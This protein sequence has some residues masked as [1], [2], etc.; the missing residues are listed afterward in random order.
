MKE[1]RAF[2]TK[3]YPEG[4]TDDVFNAY[5]YTVAQSLVHVLKQAGS[6]LSR[7]NVMKQAASIKDLALPL[8]LPGIKINTSPTDF[9]PLEQE[10]LARFDGERWVLFG[11]IYDASKK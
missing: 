3:F 7:A 2:M 11:E 1:W 6:D 5:G 4:N 9:Y 8:F 10:Q